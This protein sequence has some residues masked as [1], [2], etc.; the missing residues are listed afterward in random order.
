MKIITGII[1]KKAFIVPLAII[2]GIVGVYYIF[3]KSSTPKLETIEVVRGTVA[4]EV[5]V[6][7]KI[8]PTESVSLS[9]EG[10]GKV[11]R[12]FSRV[13]DRILTGQ[14]LVELDQK[15]LSA[16]LLQM[17][18][19]VATQN[20]KLDQLRQGTRPEEIAIQEVKVR[21]AEIA[22]EDAEQN[23][24]DR[25][26]DA[27][28][29][30]DDAV[31]NLVDQL[32]NNPRSSSPQISIIGFYQK[33][34]A[35]N[36]RFLIEQILRVW[37]EQ[38]F[39]VSSFKNATIG[40]ADAKKNLETVR[41][42]TDLIALGVN[43]LIAGGGLT[44]ATIDGYRLNISTARTNINTAITNLSAAEE[45]F[46]VANSSSLLEKNEL[47]LKKAGPTLEE[48][49]V[50]VAEVKG[51]EAKVIGIRAQIEKNI[52]RSPI[53]GI[54]TKQDAK[55]GEIIAPHS[56]IVS[57]ISLEQNEIEVFVP[58]VDIGKILIGNFV[59]ITVD[60][61]SEESF[62]GK[63]FSIEPGETIVDGVVNFKIFISFDAYDPRLKSGLTANLSI[64]T[65]RKDGVLVLP[66]FAIV[67]TD[68]G[69]FVRKR[70]GK[71]IIDVPVIIGVR[72]KE[73]LVEIVSGVS[74]GERVINVGLKEAGE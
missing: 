48:I 66:Q 46:R 45:K 8:K 9:F 16:E 64:E 42:F 56:A 40:I 11:R 3:F 5:I 72:G 10:S 15:E 39:S 73:G 19:S 2:I 38:N 57:V 21:S 30:S 35:E 61:F 26:R 52:L 23:L 29:K 58:E 63:V 59:A 53:N 50:Q 71:K 44:Q 69:V 54:I 24:F 1:L 17:E 25:L 18:A 47:I 68:N 32:F 51:A 74:E 49:A 37:A 33:Q 65:A 60:A 20:A 12:V 27:Y 55:Q 14:I 62:I 28:T 31:R 4:E 6:T 34:L 70:N 67:E 41:G 13:G 43:S 22:I 7:G 36:Q